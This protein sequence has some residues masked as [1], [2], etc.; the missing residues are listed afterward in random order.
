MR[1][2]CVAPGPTDTPL[3]AND[4]NTAGYAASLPLGRLIQ[5]QEIAGFVTFLL[6]EHTNIVGQVISPNAGAVP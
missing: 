3:L 1:V 6:L 5:P 4:P 2:N